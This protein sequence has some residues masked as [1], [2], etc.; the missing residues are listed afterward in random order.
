MRPPHRVT[1]YS[2]PCASAE[3]FVV[4]EH[5]P[6]LAAGQRTRTNRLAIP[7]PSQLSF[8]APTI[9]MDTAPPP[10]QLKLSPARHAAAAT[11][12]FRSGPP[13][14]QSLSTTATRS[15]LKSSPTL[16]PWLQLRPITCSPGLGDS[17]YSSA[18]DTNDS[19]L[20]FELQLQGGGS[21]GTTAT[22]SDT[23]VSEQGGAHQ[24]LNPLFQNSLLLPA[25][26]VELQQ[27]VCS[28]R[29]FHGRGRHM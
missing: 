9:T 1:A 6:S 10:E 5:Q 18:P 4:S 21:M 13:S 24:Y 22:C 17:N 7:L 29:G 3:L 2:L 16:A 23:E 19:Q 15:S 27:Q 20:S 25:A 14:P 8:S 11:F 12:T 26:L 28:S